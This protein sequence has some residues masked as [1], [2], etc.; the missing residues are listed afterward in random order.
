MASDRTWAAQLRPQG[1]HQVMWNCF[2]CLRS[3]RISFHQ[4]HSDS[5]D[6]D[7]LIDLLF[8]PYPPRHALSF[9]TIHVAILKSSTSTTVL[10]VSFFKRFQTVI[11]TFDTK[12]T[13]H[14]LWHHIRSYQY[15]ICHMHTSNAKQTQFKHHLHHLEP[16]TNVER[17][18]SFGDPKRS[19][20][21]SAATA[22]VAARPAEIWVP[23]DWVNQSNWV[24]LHLESC[25]Q[26]FSNSNFSSSFKSQSKLS[27]QTSIFTLFTHAPIYELFLPIYRFIYSFWEASKDCQ[28][29]H[30]VSLYHI[31]TSFR[32]QL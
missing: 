20:R 14:L 19:P 10:E 22:S 8:V 5:I 27:S 16:R 23:K 18:G 7:D 24:R 30:T 11:W 21:C 28:R 31:S 26:L 15:H 3:W 2:H 1:L 25:T 17:I 6:L 13:L 9:K 4:E 12:K 29:F 32:R